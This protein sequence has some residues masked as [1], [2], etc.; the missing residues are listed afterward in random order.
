[1]LKRGDRATCLYRDADV[2]ITGWSNGPI[3]WP[4]CKIP[5]Q[6]G[7]SGLLV[8]AELARAVRSESALAVRYLCGG[9]RPAG[10]RTG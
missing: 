3:P 2:R 10:V 4:P 9:P 1:M 5:G 8:D 7:G 6:R